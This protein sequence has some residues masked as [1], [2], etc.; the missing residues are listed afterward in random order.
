MEIGTGIDDPTYK[1]D[2]Q[3]LRSLGLRESDIEAVMAGFDSKMDRLNALFE[4]L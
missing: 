1:D 3:V 2:D 4:G